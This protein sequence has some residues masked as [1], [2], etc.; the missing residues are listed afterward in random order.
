MT[1]PF[2]RYL[3]IEYFKWGDCHRFYLEGPAPLVWAAVAAALLTD[4]SGDYCTYCL[5]THI[6]PKDFESRHEIVRRGSE[7]IEVVGRDSATREE[8]A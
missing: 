4:I 7:V 5:W 6:R 8:V 1:I 2:W 3:Y